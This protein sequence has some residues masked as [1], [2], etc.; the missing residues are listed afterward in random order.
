MARGDI[1]SFELDPDGK[2]ELLNYT[3]AGSSLSYYIQLGYQ[4]GGTGSVILT[5]QQNINSF[6]TLS[7]GTAGISFGGF[8]MNDPLPINAYV[9]QVI[10]GYGTTNDLIRIELTGGDRIIFTEEALLFIE[11]IEIGA[12]GY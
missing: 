6:R 11:K 2:K 4:I 12:V 8:V 1:I 3:F 10:I 7:D 9:T 5:A